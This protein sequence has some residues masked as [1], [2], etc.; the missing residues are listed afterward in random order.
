MFQL[1]VE[2]AN[3][4]VLLSS[5]LLNI[6]F[7]V[8]MMHMQPDSILKRESARE[9]WVGVLI[10][11]Y[12]KQPRNYNKQCSYSTFLRLNKKK[13]LV[14][15][16]HIGSLLKNLLPALIRKGRCK[17]RRG[18]QLLVKGEHMATPLNCLWLACSRYFC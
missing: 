11:Y 12:I 13:C 8:M 2:R 10:F 15:L 9:D 16:Q 7:N 18:H 17:V 4:A 3:I 6:L 5:P 1:I 14:R